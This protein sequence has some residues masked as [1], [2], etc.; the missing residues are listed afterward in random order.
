MTFFPAVQ[1]QMQNPC[2]FYILFN[3]SVSQRVVVSEVLHLGLVIEINDFSFLPLSSWV[4]GTYF[5]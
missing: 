1:V 2:P 3:H 4:G 5:E